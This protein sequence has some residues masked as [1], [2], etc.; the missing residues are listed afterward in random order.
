MAPAPRSVG[1]ASSGSSPGRVDGMTG[2]GRPRMPGDVRR[3]ALLRLAR[4]TFIAGGYH[5]T[6][7]RAIAE[8][9]GISETL[10]LKHFRSKE[11]LFR[12]AVVDPFFE[13][14]DRSGERL[15]E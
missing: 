8:A 5:A 15:E 1:S 10:V 6:T 14:L 9:A 3:A 2:S 7:T 4:S 13:L 12:A 11:E